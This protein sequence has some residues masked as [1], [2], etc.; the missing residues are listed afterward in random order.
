ME[1]S[2]KYSIRNLSRIPDAP[3]VVK[4]L[5]KDIARPR[6][7]VMI[8][9]YNCS[10][11]LR[12]TL[13]RV[14]AQDQGESLM[15]I[16]VVDDASTDA[17]VFAMVQKIGGG[18]VRYF[19]QKENVGS[20]RNFQTC[21]ERSTGH[22]VHILHGDDLIRDGFYEK[23]EGLFVAYPTIGAA[24]CRYAYIDEA[25]KTLFH[26]D[27]E[28]GSAGILD[29]WLP[30]LCERQR[31]QYV[32]MVVKREV[33]E[34]LGGFYG[35]EYGED[36]EMWV[37]IAAHYPTGYTPDVLAEYRRHYASIS[38]KS[39]VTGQNMA[40]LEWVMKRIQ[41]YLPAKIRGSVM[42][43]SRSF[44]AHYALR[45]ANALWK[46]FKDRRGASAQALAAWNMSRDAGLLFKI[47]KLYTR[48]TLNI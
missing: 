18:R 22:L 13:A 7:S 3:P 8:P 45:V 14:L 19:R 26:H 1:L 16:E 4:P 43:A 41:Q 40:S 48:I 11:F 42:H 33:Y 28:M 20:L 25:G 2:S 30:R 17:D 21:L 24:F 34:H 38:G 37:R 9:V 32:A 35:V 15:Q 46:N 44:Y 29:N 12:D 5:D 27:P 10:G 23:M 31:I 36:W 39:F 47:I 6:W